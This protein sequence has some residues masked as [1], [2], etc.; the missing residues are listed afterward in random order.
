M[1]DPTDARDTTLAHMD[2]AMWRPL[3]QDVMSEEDK[4]L[5]LGKLVLNGMNEV[6][7]GDQ[8]LAEAGLDGTPT[9]E[10][11]ITTKDGEDWVITIAR[12][13]ADKD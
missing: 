5:A 12:P 3:P 2:A 11:T 4:V 8:M 1:N 7:K 6:R 13:D 10:T 9:F